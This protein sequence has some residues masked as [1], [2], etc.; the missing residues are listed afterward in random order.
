VE[1]GK[2]DFVREPVKIEPLLREVCDVLRILADEKSVS[3]G[4]ETGDVDTVMTDPARL[5]QVAY[6]YLSNAIKF[7]PTGGTVQVRACWEG[8]SAFRMEVEDNGPG[9]QE[10]DISRLFTD[11]Q[12]LDQTTAGLGTGLCLALT[13]RIVESQ[14]GTVGVR[15]IPGKG[16]I[17]FAVLPVEVAETG[18]VPTADL[19]PE[20]PVPGTDLPQETIPV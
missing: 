16:S 20:A 15:S 3:I 12:Q 17:F 18:S 6:N 2:I 4:L 11:F 1:A 7:A 9:I 8:G 13:K 5:K 19:E 10:A 14:G